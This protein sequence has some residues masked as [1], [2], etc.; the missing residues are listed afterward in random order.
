[1]AT[2]TNARLTMQLNLPGNNA[3]VDVTGEIR[4]TPLEKFLMEKGLR[5]KVD[6]KVW[7]EDLGWWL[8]PDDFLFSYSSV[9]FP[10]AT[11]SAIEPIAFTR[12]VPMGLLNEDIGTD[13]VY[14]EIIL[15]NMESGSTT[16]K[17]TNVIKHRF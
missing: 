13:E 8:N 2:I 7:G 14:A 15:K 11:P 17:R 4:F 16:K 9:F 6:C 10:D 5:Y 12:Q 1:M 3:K